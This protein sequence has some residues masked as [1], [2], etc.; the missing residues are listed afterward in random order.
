MP[1]FRYSAR[2]QQKIVS[3][4]VQAVDCATAAAQLLAQHLEP[5]TIEPFQETA[6]WQGYR[7]RILRAAAPETDELLLFSRQMFALIHAGVPLIR[8]LQGV[9]EHT[10]HP[11]MQETLGRV[12]EELQAG[13]DLAAALAAHPHLF[14]RL[15]PRLVRVGESTGRLDDAFQQM[16]H[17][18]EMD[19]ERE[20]NLRTAIR[21]PMFV[22][23]AAIVAL[24]VVN[25]FV[26]PAFAGLFARFGAELP[27]L[28]RV[29]VGLACAER[30][31]DVE[32][33]EQRERGEIAGPRVRRPEQRD[34][35]PHHLVE[36]DRLGV[37]P[38]RLLGPAADPYR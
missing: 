22:L 6:P 7:Q 17:H 38:E 36:H 3:G 12:I 34:A 27:L 11:A 1:A 18:L 9:R 23:F 33:A 24:F 28:T 4:V 15:L 8:A 30:L 19:R 26:V 16:A 31:P 13:R 37:V 14:G 2:R 20:R 10:H 25:Y 35:L 32:Q 21:Y 5:L 29:L